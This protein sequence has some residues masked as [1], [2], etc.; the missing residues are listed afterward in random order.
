MRVAVETIPENQDMVLEQDI[1]ASQWEMDSF[2]IVFCDSAHVQ[3]GLRRIG[4]EI[5]V[6][7]RVD[8][9]R[10][11][12]CSR[13]LQEKI[14][15]VAREFTFSYNLA[16]IGDYLEID[17]DVREELLLNFPMKVLC[18]SDCKGICPECGVDLNKEQCSCKAKASGFLNTG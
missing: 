6:K 10:K 16:D 13:C 5:L 15:P 9:K 12:T 11:I 2:D 7:G 4:D 14:Q 1:A 8:V 17:N 3:A 18:K